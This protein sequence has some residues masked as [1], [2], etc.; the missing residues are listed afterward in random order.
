MCGSIE[1]KGGRVGGIELQGVSKGHH[2][3]QFPRREVQ[4][5][6]REIT[7]HKTGD[8]IR[9]WLWVVKNSPWRIKKFSRE[10]LSYKFGLER[11][12]MTRENFNWK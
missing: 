6:R 1:E 4:V 2:E 7:A 10:N 9:L 8:Y 5:A 3:T 12:K 11:P